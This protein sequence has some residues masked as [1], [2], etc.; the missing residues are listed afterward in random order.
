MLA[1][2]C[3]L[4]CTSTPFIPDACSRLWKWTNRENVSRLTRKEIANF[5][6]LMCA[7]KRKL[8]ERLLPSPNESPHDF[9]FNPPSM[10]DL[11]RTRGQEW[12]SGRWKRE[13]N[14]CG[15]LG[16]HKQR[17]IERME[18]RKV[19][20]MLI[21]TWKLSCEYG[22]QFG[23]GFG[24][25][26]ST[27]SID[28]RNIILPS[29]PLSAGL[30]TRLDNLGGS[31][32]AW[33]CRQHLLSI[34]RLILHVDLTLPLGP[35]KLLETFFYEGR[36]F[37]R[38]DLGSD[39][40]RPKPDV[41]A[42]ASQP[43]AFI[44]GCESLS[45]IA[46]RPGA[47]LALRLDAAGRWCLDLGSPLIT[48]GGFPT[49]R[50]LTTAES[51]ALMGSYHGSRIPIPFA[52]SL[53]EA[54]TLGIQDANW[55]LPTTLTAIGVAFCLNLTIDIAVGL[56]RL[57]QESMRYQPANPLLELKGGRPG[58]GSMTRGVQLLKSNGTIFSAKPGATRRK[59]CAALT[60]RWDCD[61]TSFQ[62]NM[63]TFCW[64]TLFTLKLGEIVLSQNARRA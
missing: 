44:E 17:E 55:K 15:Q 31:N 27:R 10:V 63:V 7:E 46:S 38:H 18:R 35:W 45:T 53:A 14:G 36:W 56:Q 33:E 48:H 5:G 26:E 47:P 12:V 20:V 29:S 40:S 28:R 57:R 25:G 22:D 61:G 41:L 54:K 62:L 24:I 50:M 32:Q 8:H 30:K 13:G 9:S 3:A 51:L 2:A 23:L 60:A 6:N 59:A 11:L 16:T 52:S 49:R 19:A 42:I 37:S 34:Y 39:G 1:L 43:S 64:T 58:R 21:T 4:S